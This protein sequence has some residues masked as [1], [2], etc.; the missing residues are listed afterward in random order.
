MGEDRIYLDNAA[1]TMADPEVIQAMM[2]Y[3]SQTYAVASSEFSHTPGIHA[4]EGLDAARE[5]LAGKLNCAP[6]EVVFTSGG[7]ESCNLAVKGAA[8]AQTDQ[9]DHIVCSLIEYNAVKRSCEWLEQRGFHVTYLDV[10]EEGFVDPEDVANAITDRTFLVNVQHAN[11]EVGTIQPVEEIGRI[12]SERGV[13]FHTDAVLSFTQLDVDVERF[14]ADLVSLSAH[15][16]HGPKG[17]GALYVRKG[18]KLEKLFHGG[19][20]E[21]D[22]RAGTENVTGAVGFGKAVQV[23]SAEHTQYVRDLQKSLLRLS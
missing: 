2:P 1:A 17:I 6:E 12:C 10:D 15:K 22:R 16:V 4:R 7:T 5:I 13:L 20:M 14:H 19:F 11:Q 8:W 9:K 23:A 3:F 21:F 18:V